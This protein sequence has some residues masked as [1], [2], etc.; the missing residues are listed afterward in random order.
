MS[1]F[2]TFCVLLCMAHG[3]GQCTPRSCAGDQLPQ[4]PKPVAEHQVLKNFVGEWDCE[5][6]SFME[7]GKPTKHKS[8]VSGK[9][10]GD[11]W[12]AIDVKGDLAGMPFAGHG[13]FGFDAAKKKA[14]GTWVDSMGDFLWMYDGKIEGNKL[15]L[16]AKGPSPMDPTKMIPY[17]DT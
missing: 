2:A 6:E 5:M 9:M 3:I 17:R 8:T 4:M 16:N 13:T 11:F 14:I 12:A 1:K 10:V 15:L 7:P